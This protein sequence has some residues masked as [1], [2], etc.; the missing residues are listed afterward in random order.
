L[1]KANITTG[2]LLYFGVNFDIL[3]I[4]ELNKN[5][6]IFLHLLPQTYFSW[7]IKGKERKNGSTSV[8]SYTWL[9]MSLTQDIQPNLT[10]F[11]LSRL[12][13]RL[14]G[15]FEFHEN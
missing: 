5:F 8:F 3:R 2:N 13:R 7:E 4:W 1:L 15:Q 10:I 9:Y 11:G 6:E 14:S 12:P